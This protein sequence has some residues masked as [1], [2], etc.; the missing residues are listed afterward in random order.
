MMVGVVLLRQSLGS[1][2]VNRNGLG[3]GGGM[4][5]MRQRYGSLALLV[6]WD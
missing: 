1:L 3:N 2:R 5:C 6:A 4:V